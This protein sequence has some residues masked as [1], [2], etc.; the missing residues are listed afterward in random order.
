MRLASSLVF[1]GGLTA[2]GG[3]LFYTS[4][5]TSLHTPDEVYECVQTQFKAM[6]Y[7]RAQYD[8]DRRWFVAQKVDTT[9]RVSSGTFRRTMNRIDA[10]VGADASGSTSLE[11]KVQT[12]NEFGTA[13]GL[14]S[15]EE[16][17]SALVKEDAATL[18]A[19]C[20]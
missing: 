5:S 20:K 11:L 13:A 3:P 16:R 2:C 19:A 7:S 8:V 12:F 4:K 18:V 14:Q 6:R 1:L 15:V 10:R 9:G 17:A